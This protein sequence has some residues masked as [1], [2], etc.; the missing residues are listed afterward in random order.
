MQTRNPLFDDLARLASGAMGTA[1]SVKEEMEV[2][3]RSRMERWATEMA[4]ATREE[5]DAA[6]AAATVAEERVAALS[7]R[8]AELEQALAA[9]GGAAAGAASP[10]RRPG[11]P[12]GRS[13]QPGNFRRGRNR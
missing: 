2:L 13:G 1:Q 3:M 10:A 6:M 7:A 11:R 5:V 12:K 9:G 4:F 8:V